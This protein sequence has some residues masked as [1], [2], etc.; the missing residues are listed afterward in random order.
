MRAYKYRIYPNCE[1]KAKIAQH[2]GCTRFVYNWGLETKMAQYQQNKT[3]LSC[4]DLIN[5]LKELKSENKWLKEV[6]SQSLQM[7]LR[8]L[9]NAYTRF[10]RE[11]K[12][13]PKFK[14]K[15][16]NRQSYQIPQRCL[17]VDNSHVKIPKLGVVKAKIHRKCVGKTGTWTISKTPA[18]KYF[19]SIITNAT[20]TKSCSDGIIGID[21]GIKTY[22]TCS[23]GNKIDNPKW[24]RNLSD[25][26]AVLQRRA[27]KKVKGSNNRKKANLRVAKYYEKIT[28]QRNDWQHKWSA[29]LVSENKVICLEDLNVAGML[30][31][32]RLARSIQECAWSQFVSFLEYKAEWSGTRIIE[33]GRFDPSSRLCSCGYLNRNLTLADRE[34]TCPVCH[35]THDRDLLASQNILKFGL[36]LLSGSGRP[37]EPVEMLAV[38]KSKKQEAQPLV[39]G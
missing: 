18:G 20:P 5:R 19:V 38:A 23:N 21:L 8:N 31:N 16:N 9:D 27:S 7:A 17:I 11:K 4:F 13:F 34:W 24:L 6:D 2:F 10:F 14:S 1:Q 3:T 12:G 22:A 29:K 36:K 26:L 39:V 35:T 25:R 33:I 15:H 28:N 37:V 30:K 32:H